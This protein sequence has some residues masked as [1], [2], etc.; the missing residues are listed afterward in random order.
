MVKLRGEQK[1]QFERDLTQD[2]KLRIYTTALAMYVENNYNRELCYGLSIAAIGSGVFDRMTKYIS[3][4]WIREKLGFTREN[5]SKL[6]EKYYLTKPYKKKEPWW[7]F[8]EYSTRIMVLK[9]LIH[10]LRKD[11]YFCK[12][13]GSECIEATYKNEII[14]AEFLALINMDYRFIE[15]Y[16]ANKET[17]QTLF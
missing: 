2:D 3:S 17:Q 15:N 1:T 9:V 5:I 14:D 6:C 11:E 8:V 10:E 7:D 16:K 4:F 13:N 12:F